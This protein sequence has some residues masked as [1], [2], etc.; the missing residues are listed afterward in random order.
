MTGITTWNKGKS[1]AGAD[2]WNLTANVMA[3]LESMNVIVPVANQAERDG[4]T[5]PLGKYAG[6]AVCRLDLPNM[7]VEVWDGA[8]W[9]RNDQTGNVITTDTNWGY[10]GGLIRQRGLA[11]THARMSLKMNRLG[12]NI[13]LGTTYTNL[14]NFIPSGWYPTIGAFGTVNVHTSGS[15][16]RFQVV[17]NVSVTGDILIQVP[18]GS[19]T[20]NTGD[21]FVIDMGWHA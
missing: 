11:R 1:P 4:L 12:G 15:A 9:Q 21:F 19:Q 7:Q 20:L 13:S 6:M 10:N 5:P 18:S 16:F 17:V 3:A 2:G 14:G 8:A